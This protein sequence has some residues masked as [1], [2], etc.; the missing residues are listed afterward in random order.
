VEA[1]GHPACAE[2]LVPERL[3]R[4]TRRVVVKYALL[5]LPGLALLGGGFYWLQQ[6]YEL[7]VWFVLLPLF[8]WLIKDAI[9]FPFLWRSFDDRPPER[10]P[11]PVGLVGTV[12]A[13][14]MVRVRGELWRAEP[15]EGP[16]PLPPGQ[17]VRVCRAEGLKLFVEPEIEVAPAPGSERGV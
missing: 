17:R 15:L 14:G 8:A 16:G 2:K 3:R 7:S 6:A 4:P 12:T 1:E 9:L 13:S 10:D 11:M 5:Q